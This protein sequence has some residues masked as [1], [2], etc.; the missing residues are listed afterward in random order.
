MLMVAGRTHDRTG[1]LTVGVFFETTLCLWPRLIDLDILLGGQPQYLLVW[2][3]VTT[4]N[5]IDDTT[6]IAKQLPL[7]IH[8]AEL[9]TFVVECLCANC[10]GLH[11]TGTP[12]RG[13]GCTELELHLKAIVA[14]E[15]LF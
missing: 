2:P 15:A 7:E 12:F 13:V 3:T 6:I 11:S 1:C 14:S 5:H 8:N 10:T 4:L 9:H